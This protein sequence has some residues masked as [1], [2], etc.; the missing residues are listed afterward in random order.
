MVPSLHVSQT[1][2]GMSGSERIRA[3]L[4]QL[5]SLDEISGGTIREVGGLTQEEFTQRLIGLKQELIQSWQ[6]DQ[7]VKALKIAI[8]V[9]Y[10]DM[11]LL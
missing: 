3:R 1:I 4:E 2:S 10:V 11:I 9:S 7:R 6:S 8:Q 5:D